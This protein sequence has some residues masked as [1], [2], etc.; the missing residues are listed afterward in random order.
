M[1]IK[2]ILL[3]LLLFVIVL[4][5]GL[6]IFVYSSWDKNFTN[7]FPVSDLII[8]A[9]SAMIERGRYLTNG[10]AHCS[11]CH[12][13][14]EIRS[15]NIGQ[16]ELPLSGGFGLD[17]PPGVFYAPNITSDPETGIGKFTDGELYRMFRHNIRRDGRVCVDFMPF[18]N[19]AD[20]DI[21]AI[22]TYL[23]TLE[24]VN[25]KMPDREVHFIGK[26]MF[27]FDGIKPGVPDEPLLKTITPDTTAEYGEYLA[28]SVANCK[29]CHTERDVKTGE[30][31]GIDYAGGAV[32]GP[33]NLTND[34][35]FVSS[36]LT[37]DEETG[38]MAKWDEA[39]FIARMKAGRVHVASPMPWEANQRISENDLKAI[40]RF[41]KTLQPVRNKIDP[42]ATTTKK[43]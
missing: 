6:V 32:F 17:I 35:V 20:D 39:T 10:P 14:I 37:P 15:E 38:I 29:G 5:I 3:G 25:N 12:A 11:D 8:E 7:D 27:A 34:Q 4:I 19:M 13:P 26:M 31:I 30:F 18:I 43:G 9:D 41:L 23:R 42:V 21:Y 1:K 40:Y 33:D 24:K 28:A 2:K 22:I 16:N 36:N